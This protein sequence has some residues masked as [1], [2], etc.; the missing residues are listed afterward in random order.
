[1][2]NFQLLATQAFAGSVN[3][4]LLNWP[5]WTPAPSTVP[6]LTSTAW[7]SLPENAGLAP[8]LA[9]L[10]AAYIRSRTGLGAILATGTLPAQSAQV[11]ATEETADRNLDN[12]Y[13]A[14]QAT[15]T[16]LLVR[17]AL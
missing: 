6:T 9:R 11:A 8:G 15:V 1:M 14:L 4:A 12:G 16:A 10:E 13:A 7:L 17:T 3:T 5:W 2:A